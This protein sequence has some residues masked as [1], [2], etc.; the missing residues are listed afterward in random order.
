VVTSIYAAILHFFYAEIALRPI[1][2][3]IAE[4]LPAESRAEV[5]VPLRWKLLVPCR[6]T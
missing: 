2:R 5:S 1:V 4:Y 3:E 6:S